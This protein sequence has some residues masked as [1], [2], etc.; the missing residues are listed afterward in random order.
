MVFRSKIDSFFTLVLCIVMIVIGVVTFIPLFIEQQPEIAMIITLTVIFIIMSSFVLWTTLSIKYVFKEDHLLVKGGLFKSEIPYE[1]I[2][3][4]SPTT[5]TFTGY[6][7]MSAKEGFELFSAT[8]T[9]GSVKISPTE[10]EMFLA[11][12]K[13][14]CLNVD[15]QA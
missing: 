8:V 15:I 5:E 14:R 6:R 3:K 10:R 7:I 12:I 4:V 13:K 11:E 9:F 1:K 2:T